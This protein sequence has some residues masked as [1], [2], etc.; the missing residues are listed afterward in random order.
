VKKTNVTSKSYAGS[1]RE[2]AESARIQR[3]IE[4]T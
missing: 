2:A 4:M 1:S 3:P